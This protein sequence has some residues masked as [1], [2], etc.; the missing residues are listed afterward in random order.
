MTYLNEIYQISKILS[1]KGIDYISDYCKGNT[2][3]VN[4]INKNIHQNPFLHYYSLQ[5]PITQI[6]EQIYLGNALNALDIDK[7]KSLGIKKIINATKEIPNWYPSEFEY[8]QIPIRDTRD[9]FLNQHLSLA[10]QFIN[11]TPVGDKILI[12]CYMGS[13]R[14]ASVVAYYLKQK[15]NI[16]TVSALNIVQSKRNL[17]NINTNFIKELDYN[18][19]INQYMKQL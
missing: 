16:S 11:D 4:R 13:S 1:L 6:D 15:N 18:L 8:Y 14:S 7:L 17:I 9:S 5:T 10:Y 19:N 2:R 3:E 12:H